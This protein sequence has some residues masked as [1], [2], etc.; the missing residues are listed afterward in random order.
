MAD[1]SVEPWPWP[2]CLGGS[3]ALGR[4]LGEPAPALARLL[5]SRLRVLKVQGGRVDG[6]LRLL[7]RSLRGRGGQL[8]RRAWCGRGDTLLASQRL[9]SLLGPL[10]RGLG[11]GERILC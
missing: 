3:P 2:A 10:L 7:D 5:G 8:I 1:A 6:V 4:R 11:L 9:D